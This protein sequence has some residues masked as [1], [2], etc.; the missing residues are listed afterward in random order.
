M[1]RK[2]T[3]TSYHKRR[4]RLKDLRV[5]SNRGIWISAPDSQYVYL[6]QR[7]SD[8][9]GNRASGAAS[10]FALEGE[11]ARVRSRASGGGWERGPPSPYGPSPRA[12]RQSDHR[13]YAITR[14]GK[15]SRYDPRRNVSERST[16]VMELTVHS[17]LR[18]AFIAVFVLLIT[19]GAVRTAEKNGKWWRDNLAGPDSSNYVDLDQIKKSNVS[20]LEVA[21]TYPYAAG[22]FNPIVVDDVVYVLGRNGS[23]VA[24]DATTGKEI[25]IHEGLNGMT[26]RGINYWQSDD[27]KDRR[28]LFSINNFLQ[29]IDARTGRSIPT[30][31]IEGPSICAPISRAARRWAGTTTARARSGRTC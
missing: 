28:L 22:G 21:W 30:F 31:G 8:A 29:A 19:L 12:R 16:L 24:L 5:K 2:G 27:G 25:W 6:S 13:Y 3:V 4:K 15:T 26:S 20:E 18:A 9:G 11:A 17:T 14:D 10:Q 7:Q 1:T 23:L